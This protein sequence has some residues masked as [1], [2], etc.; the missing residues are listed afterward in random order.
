MEEKIDK[1]ICIVLDQ[2]RTNL[3]PDEALNQTQ[4][5]LN[6]AHA[7]TQLLQGDQSKTKRASV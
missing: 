6:L 2:I 4:A 7:K 5:V 1:A 3:K